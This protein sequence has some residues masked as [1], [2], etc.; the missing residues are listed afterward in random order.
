MI[1]MC[2]KIKKLFNTYDRCL[3]LYNTVFTTTSTVYFDIRKFLHFTR[4][5]DFMSFVRRSD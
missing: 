4:V 5:N 1:T 3:T 2:F